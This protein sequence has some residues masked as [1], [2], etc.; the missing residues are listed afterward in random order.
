VETDIGKVP[1]AELVRSHRGVQ[2]AFAL[3]AGGLF[4]ATML[5]IRREPAP[6]ITVVA[7][8][9]QVIQQQPVQPASTGAQNPQIDPAQQPGNA[10]LPPAPKSASPGNIDMQAVQKMAAEFTKSG[11]PAQPAAHS[12][13]SEK[14]HYPNAQ[15]INLDDV[16]IPNIGIPV[17]REGYTTTDPLNTVVDYY[18]RLYPNATVTD[19]QGQKVIAVDNGSDSRVITIGNNGSETR[20]V[21]VR[22]Q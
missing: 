10:Q 22:I 21:I 14:D 11:T 12:G 19:Q 1:L 9:P 6:V 16:A 4:V 20:I 18:R 5:L 17:A 13:P 7:P 8:Q 15:A 2:I 3:A